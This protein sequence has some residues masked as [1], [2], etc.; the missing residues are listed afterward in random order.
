MKLNDVPEGQVAGRNL[1]FLKEW[2][3]VDGQY[4]KQLELQFSPNIGSEKEK[5][6]KTWLAFNKAFEDKHAVFFIAR[7]REMVDF[8]AAFI[9]EEKALARFEEVWE[10]LSNEDLDNTSLDAVQTFQERFIKGMLKLIP[11]DF[12]TV[13][14]T[15]FLHYKGQYLNI[16]SYADNNFQMTFGLNPPMSTSLNLTKPESAPVREISTETEP[17]P[18]T[19]DVSVSTE[20]DW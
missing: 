19:E 1:L 11:V 5:I 6:Y 13:P 3:V 14:V 20:E 12:Q 7:L 15:V 4:G 2:S 10:K 8:L 18:Q 9:G 17:K 16:P